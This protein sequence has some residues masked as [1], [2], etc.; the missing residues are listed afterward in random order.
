MLRYTNA[1]MFTEASCVP[2]IGLLEM[3]PLEG[4]LGHPMV[5][6]L[7][8]PVLPVAHET[9]RLWAEGQVGRQSR[10]V[11]ALR[12]QFL[13]GSGTRVVTQCEEKGNP[14]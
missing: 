6:V 9:V 7:L 13:G 3:F 8:G 12:H 5:S 4:L 11:T 1:Q 2:C 14:N 10:P